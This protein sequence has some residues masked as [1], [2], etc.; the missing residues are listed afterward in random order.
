MKTKSL[1]KLTASL[2]AALIFSFTTLAQAAPGDLDPTFGG[3]GAVRAGFGGGDDRSNA[4]AIQT[5]D[6]VVVAGHVEEGVYRRFLLMRCRSDGVADF[7]FGPAQ[8]NIVTVGGGT[9]T[10]D[11]LEVAFGLDI[12]SDSK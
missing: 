5:D 8:T 7:A 4:V 2:L 3:K 9:G 11:S 12:Q 1:P 10:T 6:K